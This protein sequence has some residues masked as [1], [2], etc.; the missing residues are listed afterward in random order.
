MFIYIGFDLQST[1]K[2][3]ELS[4]ATYPTVLPFPRSDVL[5]QESPLLVGHP[6]GVRQR[7]LKPIAWVAGLGSLVQD[8]DKFVSV[9]LVETQKC[10]ACKT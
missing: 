7:V 10:Y 9:A 6:L 4:F 5:L 1:G 3:K 8:L 2:S